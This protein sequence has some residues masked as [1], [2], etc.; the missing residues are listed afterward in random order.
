MNGFLNFNLLFPVALAAW[1]LQWAASRLAPSRRYPGDIPRPLILLA[2]YLWLLVFTAQAHKEER[3]LFPVYP[4]VCLAAAVGVDAVQRLFFA[5]FIKV[6]NRHYL[7]R[8]H[9]NVLALSLYLYRLGKPD[10]FRMGNLA[11][12]GDVQAAIWFLSLC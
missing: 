5:T 9:R 2:L 4:L 10:K 3:F 1:P 8:K 7:V 11:S 6:Q 12:L